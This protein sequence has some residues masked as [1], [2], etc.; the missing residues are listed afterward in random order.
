MTEQFRAL[1]VDKT[2]QSFTV[3]VKEL[4]FAQL[5]EGDVT[6]RVAYSSVNYKDGLATIPGGNIVRFYP[7]VPGIDLAGTVAHSN[8]PRFRE[9]DA[10]IVTGYE[11]GVSHF[12]GYSEYARV[13]GDWIVPLPAGL[14][15]KESM[16]IG[17]AG[18]T[19]ALSVYRLEANGLR[20]DR[21]PVIVT[22]AT[23]GV[24]TIAVNLLARNGYH[25]SA[26]TGKDAEH[27]YLKSLGAKEI[28]RREEVSAP[29][30][31]LD[32]ERWAGAV[33]PVG[34]NTLAY[35]LSTMKYGGSVALSGLTGGPAVSTTVF[36]FIL[37][38]VNL[39]GIDSVYC[40]MDLRRVLWERLA[41]DWKPDHLLDRVAQETTLDG[42]PEAL[43][44]IRKGAVRGRI[45]VR[46]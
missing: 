43:A 36:P 25:V 24:G 46:L 35:L 29:A 8:D 5:P 4:P 17:T 20:P 10:V 12:G 3:E 33:D 2:D 14:T 6:I 32:K 18:F 30:K 41:S 21:G 11:L 37:R 40:P 19:A 23:G 39:L 42:L 13:P 1:V 15:L 26:S 38:G 22:G 45:I 28:L 31:P 9:G 34:G 16:V 27:E 44:A 7:M